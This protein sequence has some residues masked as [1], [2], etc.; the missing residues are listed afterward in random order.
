MLQGLYVVSTMEVCMGHSTIFGICSAHFEWPQGGSPPL[1]RESLEVSSYHVHSSL[2]LPHVLPLMTLLNMPWKSL[3]TMHLATYLLFDLIW[4]TV[5]MFQVWLEGLLTIL[6]KSSIHLSMLYLG[7]MLCHGYLVNSFDQ[8]VFDAS[9]AYLVP[10]VANIT[11]LCLSL[12]LLWYAV[13]VNELLHGFL[14]HFGRT[15]KGTT[16]SL[17][18]LRKELLPRQPEVSIAQL[19]QFIVFKVHMFSSLFLLRLSSSGSSAGLV[20]ALM[21]T[22]LLLR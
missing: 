2:Y 7:A 4:S 8:L 15:M 1:R 22:Q 18:I 12:P 21:A 11:L 20:T 19:W 16:W 17:A 3:E 14:G 10:L 5:L 13:T 9:G 6:A